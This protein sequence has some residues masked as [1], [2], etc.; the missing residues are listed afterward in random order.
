MTL[1]RLAPRIQAQVL[2]RQAGAFSERGLRRIA[3]IEEPGEQ[4]AAFEAIA[5]SRGEQPVA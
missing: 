2:A 1:L 5:G 3:M 4:A